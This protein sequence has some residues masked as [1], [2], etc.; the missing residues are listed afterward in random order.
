[1]RVCFDLFWGVPSCGQVQGCRGCRHRENKIRQCMGGRTNCLRGQSY[2]S[3]P[4]LRVRCS[5]TGDGASNWPAKGDLAL[6][7]TG[8]FRSWLCG[9][10]AYSLIMRADSPASLVS[11]SERTAS[12]L[13]R[14][15]IRFVSR[16]L[17]ASAR[18]LRSSRPF[19]A[20]PKGSS[21]LATALAMST[22][23]RASA[24]QERWPLA[25]AS[26][27]ALPTWTLW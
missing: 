1:M 21:S 27:S 20:R 12:S 8:C 25:A 9:K 15:P 17:V 19:S 5:L 6:L 3:R 7:P 16:N 23:W 13:S 18:S 4:A 10:C 22:L 2:L 24:T 11:L 14:E 26:L